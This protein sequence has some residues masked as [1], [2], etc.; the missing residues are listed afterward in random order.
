VVERLDP[1]RVWGFGSRADAERYCDQ[2]LLI[3]QGMCP[4]GHGLMTF[5][6]EFQQCN[7]CQFATNCKPELTR[8]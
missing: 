1:D 3:R 4:N 6:S 8:N 5:D 2:D 7:T